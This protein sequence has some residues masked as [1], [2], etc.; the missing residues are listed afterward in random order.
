M[1]FEE[2]LSFSSS[3]TESKSWLSKKVIP[4]IRCV[5]SVAGKI[6]TVASVF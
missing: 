1:P 4:T 6:A 5:G 3:S 2:K